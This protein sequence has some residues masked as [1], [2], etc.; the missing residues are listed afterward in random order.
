MREG[1]SKRK[2]GKVAEEDKEDESECRHA[3]KF[4]M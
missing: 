4:E 2:E 3:V 1:E